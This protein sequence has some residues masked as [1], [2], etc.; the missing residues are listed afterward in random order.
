[1]F[2]VRNPMLT[3]HFFTYINTMYNRPV[4]SLA[5]E[6]AT[7]PV[8][9]WGLNSK[10][11]LLQ[12]ENTFST[13]VFFSFFFVISLVD[14]LYCPFLSRFFLSGYLFLTALLDSD[15]LNLSFPG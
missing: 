4:R 7:Q 2:T 15:V 13:L 8:H 1:M 6:V 12:E 10:E 11:T 3:I 5:G 14:F 9:S